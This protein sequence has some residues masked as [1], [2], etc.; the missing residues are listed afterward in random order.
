[1]T[2]NI[3]SIVLVSGILLSMSKTM[4]QARVNVA[5][6]IKYAA[7]QYRGM[8]NTLNPFFRLVPTRICLPAGGGSGLFGGSLWHLF[9][10]TKDTSW[11]QAAHKWTMAVERGKTNTHTHHLGFMLYCPF[12]NGYRLTKSEAC[13][14]IMLTGA[15]SLATRFNPSYGVIKSNNP[16]CK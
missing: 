3:R 7:E 16:I 13:K 15:N 6:E 1:M 5:R 2:L 4:A 11:R 14:T 12:G 8:L 10:A 9:E